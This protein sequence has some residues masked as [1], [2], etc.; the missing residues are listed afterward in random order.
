[1]VNHDF[2]QLTW[3]KVCCCVGGD[4]DGTCGREFLGQSLVC[5]YTCFLLCLVVLVST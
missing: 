1:M 3:A 4:V 5:L 2:A